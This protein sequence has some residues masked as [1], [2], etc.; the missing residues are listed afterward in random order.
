[1][2]RL[3][4]HIS[5]WPNSSKTSFLGS[6]SFKTFFFWYIK[7]IQNTEW[8]YFSASKSIQLLSGSD[9][10]ASP[11]V[12]HL[13][14]QQRIRFPHPAILCA[15]TSSYFFFPLY[16][17]FARVRPCRRFFLAAASAGSAS[18]PSTTISPK[19]GQR[20]LIT[21]VAGEKHK[22]ADTVRQGVR[23]RS[24]EKSPPN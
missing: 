11:S 13:R 19:T 24:A 14:S 6:N 7:Q 16:R 22:P 20:Q 21:V 4:P 1:V 23:L 9:A 5:L 8:D 18:A 15:T 17:C 3:Y 10:C 12:V 2:F